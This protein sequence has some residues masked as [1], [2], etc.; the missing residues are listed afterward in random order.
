[1]MEQRGVAINGANISQ[2]LMCKSVGVV[3]LFNLN[4]R[5]L[6]TTSASWTL[7]GWR[8]EWQIG[9]GEIGVEK[10][11]VLTDSGKLIVNLLWRKVRE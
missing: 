1:M 8:G 9:R 2:I 6:V 11:E 4:F 10:G 3:D 7:G 5:I